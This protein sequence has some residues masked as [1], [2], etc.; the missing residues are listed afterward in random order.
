MII[1]SKEDFLNK[2]RFIHFLSDKLER[3]GWSTEHA[4]HEANVLIVQT[5]LAS[6]RTRDT[7]LIGDDT[8]LLVLLLYHADMTANELFLVSVS[9]QATKSRRVWCIKQ[10]KELLGRQICDH[11]L[12]VHGI[13][14]CDTTS[15]LFGLGKGLAVV[16]VKTDSLFREQSKMF[17]KSKQTPEDITAAGEKALVSLYV[18]TKEEGL[19]SLRCKR[20]CDKISKST[21]SV[22]PKTLPPTSAATK[23]HS[24]CVYYQVMEWKGTC[25]NMKP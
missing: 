22:E 24:L 4:K 16:K 11:L 2:Q 23:F 9:K 14:G 1:Q 6:A 3:A 18:G 10:S 8:D 20:F 19:D 21:S 17:H 5:A 25:V 12:F 15:R 7:V 13:L